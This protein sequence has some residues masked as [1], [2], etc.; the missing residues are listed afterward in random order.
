LIIPALTNARASSRGVR[1]RRNQ[2][3]SVVKDRN[4]NKKSGSFGPFLET[5]A[6]APFTRPETYPENSF[7]ERK[8]PLPLISQNSFAADIFR[9]RIARISDDH[10]MRSA[11]C[12]RRQRDRKRRR[13][14]QKFF[15]PITGHLVLL[16]KKNPASS[17]SRLTVLSR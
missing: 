2:A 4:R 12:L 16:H 17:G 3:Y 13:N 7:W 6:A 15:V 14:E 10:S 9:E 8:L 5:E 11:I 1:R